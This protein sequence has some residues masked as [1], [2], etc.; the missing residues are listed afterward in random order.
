MRT[1]AGCQHH[2]NT[3]H[4]GNG[5]AHALLSHNDASVIVPSMQHQCWL[6]F[7][8]LPNHRECYMFGWGLFSQTSAEGGQIVLDTVAKTC[9][10]FSVASA[11]TKSHRAPLNCST[12]LQFA[13]SQHA[14]CKIR[15]TTR[16]SHH[17]Q[18]FLPF[19]RR[20]C[21]SQPSSM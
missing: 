3:N 11:S 1:E 14:T 12:V 8:S 13:T 15:W 20:V 4:R 5:L 2:S 10:Y 19:H 6:L 17:V 9:N 18:V 21:A 16:S 7:C